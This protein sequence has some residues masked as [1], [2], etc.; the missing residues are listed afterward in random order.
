MNADKFM[1]QLAGEMVS[2]VNNNYEDNYDH[3]RFGKLPEV[4]KKGSLK[5]A[6]IS[7]L[8]KKGYYHDSS[9]YD[10]GKKIKNINYPLTDFIYLY[11][12]LTDQAS[13]DLLVKIVAYRLLGHKKVKL[14]LNTAAFWQNM[15]LI[16]SKQSKDDFVDISFMNARLPLT[17]LQFLGVPLKIYYS[18]LGINTNFIIK[19]YEFHRQ[20][21]NIEVVPGDVVIDGGGCFGDTALYFAN[22]TGAAGAVHVFEFIPDNIKIFRKNVSINKE[23]ESTIH[24]VPNPMWSES[25]KDVFYLS[26]GP[27]S[28]VDMEEF[29]GYTG[30]T[31]TLSIDDYCEESKLDK[32][33]FIKMDIEGAEIKALEGARKTITAYKPKLAIALYHS[34]EDFDR[35]PRFIHELELGYCF[36]LSHATIYGEETVLFAVA[37]RYR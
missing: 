15:E 22:K 33:D 18:S 19:Q 3:Y 20:A 25:G 16:E 12:I 34:T 1:M 23:L 9:S 31:K 2:A 14:P 11:N 4:K 32:V 30:Q 29:K 37:R 8:N 24:L 28:K 5:H 10:L 27:G 36:Y 21:V 13:K 7:F 6:V 35:I 17:D 26:D